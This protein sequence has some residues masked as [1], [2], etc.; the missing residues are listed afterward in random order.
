MNG[1]MS[2]EELPHTVGDLR[3]FVVEIRCRRCGRVAQIDP[4]KLIT[5]GGRALERR[6]PLTRFLAALTCTAKACGEKP[7]HL[8]IKARI[9]TSP[10]TEPNPML[11]W[12]MDRY[13]RWQWRGQSSDE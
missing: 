10:N 1:L 3:G 12:M 7:I 8:H 11:E 9:P 4:E 5:K 13:G 6:M 2:Q